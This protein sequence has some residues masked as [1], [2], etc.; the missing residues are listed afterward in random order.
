LRL[1]VFRR[2]EFKVFSLQKTNF[3]SEVGA[4]L[5]FF[6]YFFASRQ[7]SKW[8]FRGRS[9]LPLGLPRKPLLFNFILRISNATDNY[10][11]L[12]E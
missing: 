8:G 3:S 5:I 2:G 6:A 11:N 12:N 1:G 10:T 7:K 4:V 9:A